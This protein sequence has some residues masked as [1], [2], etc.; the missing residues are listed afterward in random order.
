MSREAPHLTPDQEK[1]V[2]EFSAALRSDAAVPCR[3]ICALPNEWVP[4][5]LKKLICDCDC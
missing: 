4:C 5:W 3:I 2:A 1:Q